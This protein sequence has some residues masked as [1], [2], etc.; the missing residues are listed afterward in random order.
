MIGTINPDGT[1]FLNDPTGNRRF[2]VVH[3]DDIDWSYTRIDREQLWAELYT[4][5]LRGER[6]ELTPYEQEIQAEINGGH[7]MVSPLEELLLQYYDIDRADTDHFT[8]TMEIL[9]RLTTLGLK[10]DQ[11]KQKMEL[12][13]I[14][15]KMGLKPDQR[16]VNGKAMRGY[17]GVWFLSLIHI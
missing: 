7:M 12:A 15:T 1:G 6:W 14:L 11:F 17:R 9:D 3:L 8:P 13:T 4:A 16:R 2:A 10:G 5:Y